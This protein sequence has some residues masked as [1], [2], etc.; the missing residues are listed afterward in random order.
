MTSILTTASTDTSQRQRLL[1]F[2]LVAAAVAT[3][4]IALFGDIEEQVGN[5]EAIDIAIIFAASIALWWRRTYVVAVAVAV[6]AL[7]VASISITGTEIAT[8]L[9]MAV[10]F[11]TLATSG[12]RQWSYPAAIATAVGMTILITSVDSGESFPQE[13][14][15]ELAITLLPVTY[16]EV[17]RGRAQRL[18]SAIDAESQLRVQAERIRIA[19]D[20]HDVVAHGLTSIAVQSGTA[21]Y[22]HPSDDPN[23]PTRQAL[24]RINEVGKRSLEELR[25]MVGVLRSTDTDPEG[26][27]EAPLRPTPTDPDN[28]DDLIASASLAGI[29]LTVDIS[30]SFPSD[31]NGATI[32][33]AHRIAQEAITN[34]ARHAGPVPASVTLIHDSDR[35]DLRITNS[36][37]SQAAPTVAS[38]GVGILGMRER[39]ESTGGSLTTISLGAGGFEVQALLPYRG[40]SV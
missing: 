26:L 38:S 31:T 19:R 30:G 18:A 15:A 7:R 1:D 12:Q 5:I 34:V 27:A 24:E 21:A 25:V 9:A 8:A 13:L 39:A 29:S 2:G 6:V 36:T 17:V 23:D 33:A 3:G 10:A 35:V 37:S 11:F 40:P 14:L 20:L 28:F 32:V 4:V 16:G 22:N